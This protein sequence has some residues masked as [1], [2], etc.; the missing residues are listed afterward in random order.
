MNFI[1]KI[2]YII[3]YKHETTLGN[4]VQILLV[5]GTI[6]SGFGYIGAQ[7]QSLKL[8]DVQE[9]RVGELRT[10]D[11]D[12]SS[13]TIVAIDPERREVKVQFNIR[14]NMMDETLTIGRTRTIPV[15]QSSTYSFIPIGIKITQEDKIAEFV[16]RKVEKGVIQ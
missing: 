15:S 14:G 1:K 10:F 6:L 9:L 7:I 3:G 2:G 16:I 4:L 8:K 13:I 5:I 11:D 12:L